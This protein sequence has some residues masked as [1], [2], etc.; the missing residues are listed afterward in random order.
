MD[1]VKKQNSEGKLKDNRYDFTSC[2]FLTDALNMYL[3]DEGGAT[4]QEL[5]QINVQAQRYFGTSR[6]LSAHCVGMRNK[7]DVPLY[8]NGKLFKGTAR[9]FNELPQNSVVWCDNSK[10]KGRYAAKLKKGNLNTSKQRIRPTE[11]HVNEAI[12]LIKERQ[13]KVSKI[14]EQ[15]EFLGEKKGYGFI[16]GWKTEVKNILEKMSSSRI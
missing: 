11:K 7:R 5:N 6:T 10:K 9:E 8:V 3:F 1:Y 2:K 4:I 13:V 14:F 12:E 15:M 16:E